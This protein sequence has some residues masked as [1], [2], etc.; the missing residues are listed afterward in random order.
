M[1]FRLDLE[2]LV[3]LLPAL[4]SSLVFHEFA[5]AWAAYRLG[6]PTAKNAGRLT[7][8]P[9][10]HLDLTGSLMI[11]FVGFG[12]AKPVPVDGRRLAE[13]RT[14]MM[15]VA[16]AGPASNLLLAFLG[17]TVLRT[18]GFTGSMETVLVMFTY[19]NIMLAVFNMIPVPPLDGSQILAGFIGQKHPALVVKMHVYGPRVL[20]GLIVFGMVTDFSPLWWI[21]GPPVELL[22]ALFVGK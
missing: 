10:A 4:V 21:M 1:L 9:L 19:I 20:L 3:M 11:L 7:L 5:H 13:P 18:T 12:W 6:D 22:M 8:N 17:G 16:F 15:K 14:D 2:V